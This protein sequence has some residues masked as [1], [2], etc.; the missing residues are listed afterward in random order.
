LV[1]DDR[2][3]QDRVAHHCCSRGSRT[4]SHADSY[5]YANGNCHG[6]SDSYCYSDSYGNPYGNGYTDS[7]SEGHSNRKTQPGIK[8]S[9]HS[10][11]SPVSGWR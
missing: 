11:A 6:N 1:C 3:L 10:A 4:P 5:A 8:T 7:N 2:L 9:P